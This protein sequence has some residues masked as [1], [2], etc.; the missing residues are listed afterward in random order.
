MEFLCNS[1]DEFCESIRNGNFENFREVFVSL[2]AICHR[3]VPELGL[4]DSAEFLNELDDMR[5]I[6]QGTGC[7]IANFEEP[8]SRVL[9]GIYI[10]GVKGELTIYNVINLVK[11]ARRKIIFKAEISRYERE[12]PLD[13][14]LDACLTLGAKFLVFKI[15]ELVRCNSFGL[16]EYFDER[17]YVCRPDE[18]LNEYREVYDNRKF[19]ESSFDEFGESIRNGTFGNFRE[20][21]VSLG[22]ICH[23]G[24]PELGLVDSAE[25][26]NELDN[27][28]KS[29]QDT[30]YQ[31]AN[32][33]EPISMM[34]RDMSHLEEK[35]E[36]TIDTVIN[37]VK[38]VYKE[39]IKT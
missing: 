33:A 21:F 25:F 3:G 6:C 4:A 18:R 38:E 35:G 32:L 20:V 23:R 12:Q 11:K 16:A 10:L 14:S 37:L 17:F 15:K 5:R 19:L 13:P 2:G 34:L 26:L 9:E 29:C 27:T 1:S 8:I 30:G 36:L 24:V 22:A 28:R 39:F 31:I 7:E